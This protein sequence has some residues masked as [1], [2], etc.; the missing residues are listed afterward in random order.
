MK[1]FLAILALLALISMT[2]VE[3]KGIGYRHV[4]LIVIMLSFA[5]IALASIGGIL[6]LYRGWP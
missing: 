5:L 4:V 2:R 3:V 6:V 1:I